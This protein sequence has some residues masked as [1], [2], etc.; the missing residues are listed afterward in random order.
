MT[1][2]F[3]TSKMNLFQVWHGL[4]HA[5]YARLTGKYVH[6]VMCHK[7][8]LMTAYL[9]VMCWASVGLLQLEVDTKAEKLGL[10]RNSPALHD[11]YIL[12]QTF[13][14]DQYNERE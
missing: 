1:I 8:K 9:L 10:V 2:Q 5:K 11:A 3:R 13:G 14:S 12:N 6:L 7:I 4:V